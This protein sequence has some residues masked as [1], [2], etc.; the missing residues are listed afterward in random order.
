MKKSTFLLLIPMTVLLGGANGDGC[1]SS[2]TD[3][4]V[5]NQQAKTLAE[6]HAQVGMPEIIN[7]QE[8]RML[9]SLYELRDQSIATH[10]YIVNQMQ[11]CLVYLGPS[12]GYGM[13]YATQFSNP[14]VDA[15][16]TTSSVAHI[17]LPQA[18]PNGLYMPPDAH[19]TWVML[20]DPASDN[21]KPVYIEPDVIVSPFR[22]T[23][24]ECH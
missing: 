3:Q 11:G 23:A 5:A 15:Y 19:G 6:A 13:P 8:K 12:I 17:A 20:K 4:V 24:R 14:Q 1:T 21:V 7:W 10:S 22:L 2:N 9:K 16:Y 18:E